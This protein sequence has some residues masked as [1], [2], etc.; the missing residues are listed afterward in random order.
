[1]NPSSF[2]HAEPAS[3]YGNQRPSGPDIS[4]SLSPRDSPQGVHTAI[5]RYS[6]Q[7]VHTA[8]IRYSPPAAP[9]PAPSKASQLLLNLDQGSCGAWHRGTATVLSTI[10]LIHLMKLAAV[11][12]HCC[13]L[14]QEGVRLSPASPLHA[15]TAC[16]TLL[17]SKEMISC[18][19]A[20]EGDLS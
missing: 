20:Q 19:G 18:R 2:L 8:I 3:L 14:L 16:T 5:I 17:H 11:V 1:M 9:P 15:C 7:G 4:Y 10:C 13:T 12:E 6:P